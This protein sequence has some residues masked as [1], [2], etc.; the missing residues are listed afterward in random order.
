M[1]TLT[2]LLGI[3][4]RRC[5]ATPALLLG[6][7]TLPAQ[8]QVSLDVSKI[9]CDQYI[10]AKIATPNYI[11]AWVSGYYNAKRNNTIIDT[12][13]IQHN[14]SKLENYCYQE[15]NFKIPLM[16]AVEDLLAK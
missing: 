14:I 13:E 5:L 15:K 3:A 11:A 9:T 7:L 12:Q 4:V 1:K 10:H 6:S 16:K 2:M 8:S